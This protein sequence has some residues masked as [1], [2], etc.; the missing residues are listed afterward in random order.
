MGLTVTVGVFDDC[1]EWAAESAEPDTEAYEEDFDICREAEEAFKEDFAFINAAFRKAGLPEHHEPAPPRPPAPWSFNMQYGVIHYLRRV[2]AHLWTGRPVPPP[3]RDEELETGSATEDP[4]LRQF[5]EES[6]PGPL[7]KEDRS[8]NLEGG[9]S[10]LLY[11][12]DF[13]GYYVPVVFPEPF[14]VPGKEGMEDIGYLGSSYVLK[15]ECERLA[16]AL[17]IPLDLH[18]DTLWDKTAR[19][20][21]LSMPWTEHVAETYACV[22]LLHACRVSIESGCAISFG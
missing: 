18:P 11:H 13:S 20:W 15:E 22:N 16:V 7:D 10:H 3:I 17:N 12:S 1:A 5:Y 14:Y 21:E 8:L 19:P 6:L 4:V 9:Y 2:A